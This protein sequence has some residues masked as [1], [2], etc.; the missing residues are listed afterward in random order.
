MNTL[1][2]HITPIRIM[3]IEEAKARMLHVIR[4]LKL[5][6]SSWIDIKE[7]NSECIKKTKESF[8]QDETTSNS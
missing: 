8:K 6:G 1:K 3:T 5:Q 7:F 4:T 2:I